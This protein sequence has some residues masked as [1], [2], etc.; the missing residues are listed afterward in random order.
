MNAFELFINDEYK[1]TASVKNGVVSF[2]VDYILNEQEINIRLGSYDKEGKSHVVW[3]KD[4]LYLNDQIKLSIKDVE[5][6]DLSQPISV[7]NEEGVDDMILQSK[8]KSYHALQKELMEKG[9][10]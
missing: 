1:A 9:L 5:P 6:K 3:F 10:I 4:N 7:S 2:T 8:I